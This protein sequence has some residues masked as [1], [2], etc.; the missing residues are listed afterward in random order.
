[1]LHSSPFLVAYAEFLILSTYLFGAHLTDDELSK[2][3]E[4]IGFVKHP[5]YAIGPIILKT[6]FT[7]MFWV[8]LRQMLRERSDSKK[9]SDLADVNVPSTDDPV[10]EANIPENEFSSMRNAAKEINF[11]VKFWIFIVALTLL[12][13]AVIGNEVTGFRIAYMT[14][15]LLFIM[16]FQVSSLLK[17]CFKFKKFLAQ[18][19]YNLWRKFL[20]GF[21][22][23]AIVCSIVVLVLVYVYQFPKTA[24]YF[25][26]FLKITEHL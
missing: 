21:L 13:C 26:K 3:F 5:H 22:L 9:L 16:I 6:A 8:S 23:A 1:M 20:K 11:L 2:N 14:M 24:E 12:L 10:T 19:S 25:E 18:F 7:C 17:N 15:F 4:E